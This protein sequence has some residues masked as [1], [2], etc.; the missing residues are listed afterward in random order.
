VWPLRKRGGM[1]AAGEPV[2][3]ITPRAPGAP[4]GRSA[5]GPSLERSGR[6]GV[7]VPR[8][9]GTVLYVDDDELNRYAFTGLFRQEGFTVEEAS[10]GRE[11]LRLVETRPDLVILDVHLPDI[12]GFEVCRRIKL[13][14][15]TTAIPV[16]H[17]SGVHFTPE[18]K[19][20]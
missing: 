15:T 18:E 12:D 1:R 3:G 11:A 13:H 19:A 2:W 5:Q 17:M 9:L 7:I 16:M 8:S 10:T 6:R 20:H 14:P 4:L